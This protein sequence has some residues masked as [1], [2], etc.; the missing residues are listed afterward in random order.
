VSQNACELS[1]ARVEQSV[2]PGKQ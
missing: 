1:T 2:G